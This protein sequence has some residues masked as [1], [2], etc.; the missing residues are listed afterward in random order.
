MSDMVTWIIIAMF[1]VVPFFI[2]YLIT[3]RIGLSLGVGSTAFVLIMIFFA[4][5]GSAGGYALSEIPSE[6]LEE[7]VIA[8]LDEYRNAY[9]ADP[10]IRNAI[11]DDLCAYNVKRILNGE[12]W[13][14]DIGGKKTALPQVDLRTVTE[15]YY[16]Q[17]VGMSGFIRYPSGTV[18][19]LS[20]TIAQDLIRLAENDKDDWSRL[21]N[22]DWRFISIDIQY[23]DYTLA[24]TAIV[25]TPVVTS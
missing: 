4:I 3:K 9:R 12:G 16:K 20:T 11:Y 23:R 21:S 19:T 25:F 2:A 15:K 22:K 1:F 17:A 14:H 13:S 6:E 24:W 10:L 18:D 5:L 8:E 7:A